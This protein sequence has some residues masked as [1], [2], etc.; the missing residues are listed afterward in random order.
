MHKTIEPK[1]HGVIDYLAAALLLLGPMLFNFAG[2]A[3]S[4]CYILGI[5]V[6]A[7][8]ILTRYPL[9]L[10][11]VIPFKIHGYVELAAGIFLILAPFLF[12]FTERSN[13]MWF[14]LIVGA[15]LAVFYALSDYRWMPAHEPLVQQRRRTV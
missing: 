15:G 4:L 1:T 6:F 10:A 13:A 2:V 8:S 9:G 11:K 14:F 5:A 12:G 3:A 7:L